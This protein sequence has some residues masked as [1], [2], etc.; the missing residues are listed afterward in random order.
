[1]ED[2]F[3]ELQMGLT[4]SGLGG[5]EGLALLALLAAAAAYLTAPALGYDPHRRGLL[6]ASMWVLV[7]RVVLGAMILGLMLLSDNV[8]LH[9]S[10][11]KAAW[12]M[13]RIFETGIFI[14]AL[15]LFVGGLSSLRRREVFTPPRP[16]FGDED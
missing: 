6:L 3:L 8:A 10:E 14:L 16:R 9:Q 13:Y 5:G 11:M 4:F 1:M 7:G 15:A 12:M 2:R